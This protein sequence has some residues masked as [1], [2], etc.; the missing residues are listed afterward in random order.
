LGPVSGEGGKGLSVWIEAP[1]GAIYHVAEEE[2][3][4]AIEWPSGAD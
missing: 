3:E 1:T 2:W 4:P